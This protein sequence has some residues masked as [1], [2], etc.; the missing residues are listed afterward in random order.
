MRYLVISDIH[1]NLAAL[2]AVLDD[3]PHGLP[4][5]CLGDVVGY[6][7]NPNECVERLRGLNPECIVG[8]HDWAV[9]GRASLDDFNLEAKTAVRWT[10]EQLTSENLAYLEDLPISLVKGQFTL[11]H[12]SPR[13]PIW[14]YIIYPSSASLNFAYFSTLYCLVGHTHIPVVFRFRGQSGKRVCEAERFWETS[15]RPLGIERL[16]INPGSVGQPRD[17]DPRASYIILDTGEKIIEYH[18]VPYDIAQTQ[19]LMEKA[20]LPQRLIAR[21]AY[22]W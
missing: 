15:T 2:D 7:P 4:V 16:I 20:N 11:V 14:E 22:G 18:R 8:N 1:S 6:G 5:W 13:E 12:G 19:R 21:L 3:A 17:G 10:Q 9:L